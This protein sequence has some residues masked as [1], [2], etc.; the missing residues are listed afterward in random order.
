MGD[1]YEI[2][3]Y[4]TSCLPNTTVGRLEAVIELA[5]PRPI[6]DA[7]GNPTGEFSEPLIS[8]AQALALLTAAQNRHPL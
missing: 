2:R 4:T 7:D 5:R 1:V 6:L 3:S 8:M